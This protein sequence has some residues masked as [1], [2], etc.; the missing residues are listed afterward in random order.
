MVNGPALFGDGDRYHAPL[1][2]LTD[3]ADAPALPEGST[4]PRIGSPV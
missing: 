4:T 3:V 2:G 1:N